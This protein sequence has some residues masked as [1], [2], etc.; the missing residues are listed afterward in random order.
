MLDI[1]GDNRGEM[2]IVVMQQYSDYRQH[3]T[4]DSSELL[5]IIAEDTSSISN[6][7]A[8]HKG[9]GYPRL[10]LYHL[11]NNTYNVDT[12]LQTQCHEDGLD[13]IPTY[14]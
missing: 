10:L 12:A 4:F 6:S 14:L 2:I 8:N 3:G 5:E 13:R 1:G 9:H 11:E 7:S